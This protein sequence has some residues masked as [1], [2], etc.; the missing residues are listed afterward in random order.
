MPETGTA[1]PDTTSIDT[2]DLKIHLVLPYINGDSS[3]I[4][5]KTS[6]ISDDYRFY[7]DSTLNVDVLKDTVVSQSRSSGALTHIMVVIRWL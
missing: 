7:F 6:L 4:D 1:K 5:I 2:L 3:I